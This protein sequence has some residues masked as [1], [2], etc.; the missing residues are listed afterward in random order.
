MLRRHYLEL[1]FGQGNAETDEKHRSVIGVS[2]AVSVLHRTSISDTEFV[3]WE[4]AMED[5]VIEGLDG[6]CASRAEA[7]SVLTFNIELV[8]YELTQK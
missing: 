7:C 8:C 5:G 2:K 6:E 3:T 4:C 1:L